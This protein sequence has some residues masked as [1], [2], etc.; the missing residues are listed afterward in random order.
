MDKYITLLNYNV[1]VDRLVSMAKELDDQW[2]QS[3]V[4][5][6]NNPD[7]KLERQEGLDHFKQN[8]NVDKNYWYIKKILDDFELP[9]N[10]ASPK[11]HWLAPNS[12][13]ETHVD[14]FTKCSINFIL[15]SDTAPAPV[16]FE[17][18]YSFNYKQALL[19]TKV[20]HG[21]KNGPKARLVFRISYYGETYEE[22]SKRI[23]YKI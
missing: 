5:K 14:E 15:S 22:L 2:E 3:Y 16:T 20:P 1:E 6:Y 10:A 7:A 17:N 9:H 19:N 18:Q 13:L 21:V 23:K 8:M 4:M 11:F 12:V